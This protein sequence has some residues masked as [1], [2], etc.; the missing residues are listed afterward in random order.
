M[1]TGSAPHHIVQRRVRGTKARL[2][3]DS[4][5]KQNDRIGV[6]E[7]LLNER[8]SVRAFLPRDVD[9]ATIE[10]VLTTAQRTASWCNS[11]P[12]QVVI[13]S[14]EAKERFRQLIYKEASGGLGDD[15]DFT[16]PREYAGVYLERRRESGFQLYNTLG[17]ARGDRSAYAKLALENY[18]FFGAPHVA[19]I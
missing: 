13:A 19:I 15:Y 12:W 18:N 9:R 14:G 8:Y 3:M 10:H 4:K 7:E 11:Q 2:V 1:G 5:V 17:I 16:P 6:L